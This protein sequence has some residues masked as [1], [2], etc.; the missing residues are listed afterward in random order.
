MSCI[1][2]K[3]IFQKV[4]VT[5]VGGKDPYNLLDVNHSSYNSE[6]RSKKRIYL[7]KCGYYLRTY[8]CSGLVG[9]STEGTFLAK[10]I[11]ILVFLVVFLL[12]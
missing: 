6:G 12:V 10:E 8:F 2:T 7:G 5:F 1:H 3:V 4:C 11:D 9:A